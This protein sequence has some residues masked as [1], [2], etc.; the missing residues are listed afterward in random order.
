MSKRRTEKSV[1]T[2][3]QEAGG[4][5]DQW[6]LSSPV[7]V[8]F[9]FPTNYNKIRLR[10]LLWITYDSLCGC[11]SSEYLLVI[12]AKGLEALLTFTQQVFFFF[13]W[14]SAYLGVLSSVNNPQIIHKRHIVENTYCAKS[15]P[16][17]AALT[18]WQRDRTSSL[19]QP[20]LKI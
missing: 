19:S 13:F 10:L 4:E 17:P 12:T 1:S 11:Q 5:T 18:N 20:S 16:R 7:F 6:L 8:Y 2:Y 9:F 3:H 14:D 15:V